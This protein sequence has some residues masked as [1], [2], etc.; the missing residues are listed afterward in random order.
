MSQI[1]NI[2]LNSKILYKVVEEE[3]KSFPVGRTYFDI[4]ID[5]PT[6]YHC[7]GLSVTSI[8]ADWIQCFLT[9]KSNNAVNVV[10][11][12]YFTSAITSN[13]EITAILMK[14]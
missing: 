6:G 4:P 8:R 9:I 13:I 5:I 2:L 12:N 3:D 10:A 7:A 11:Y 1:T 14:D